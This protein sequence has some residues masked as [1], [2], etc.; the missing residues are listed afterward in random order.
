VTPEEKRRRHRNERIIATLLVLVL[1][2]AT[3]LLYRKRLVLDE[4]VRNDRRY[5]PLH[6]QFSP[7]LTQ[8]QEY[9][10]LDTSNPPGQELP[11]ARW[12][13]GILT[14]NGVKAEII[15]TAPGRANVYA[16]VKGRRTGDGLML[17]HHIDVIPA[18]GEGW[19]RPPFAAEIYFNEV[20]GRG[21]IDMKGIGI[22]F[23]RAFLDVA[24]SGR[25]PEHDLVFLAVADEEAGG[26]LGMQWLLTNRSDVFAGVR[27][28]LN[29]GGITEMMEEKL[30][31]FGVEIGTKQVITLLLTAPRRDQLQRAR[32]ALEVSPSS[33]GSSPVKRIGSCPR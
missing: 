31:Y 20:Y 4:E 19:T 26:G 1:G 32:I 13:A 10:R 3:F 7:E 16:R 9:L 17:T 12:L 21:A 25:V 22:C 30:T 6:I 18:T 29:E 5:V 27:Y 14:R 15:E 33:R 2:S 11:A 24:T 28:A 23:L 8:L